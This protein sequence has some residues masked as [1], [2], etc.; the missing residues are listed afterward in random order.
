MKSAFIWIIAFCFFA[1]TTI[2]A[3]T[4]C[5][6]AD[7]IQYPVDTTT[8]SLAQDYGVPSQRH[9]GRY[10]TG[11]DW[12][13]GRGSSLG[14]PVR[15]AARGMVMLSSPNAW[16]RDGGV[17]ILR[18]DFAD[19]TTAFTQYG[20]ITQ[21]ETV[22]FPQPLTC[23]DAGEVIAVIGDA[24]PAPHLH[25]E[26]RVTNGDTPGPGYSWESPDSSGWRD[27]SDFIINMQSRLNP[28][29]AWRITINNPEIGL[30]TPPLVL[31]D[32]SLLYFDQ[33]TI[34]R[35]TAD[36]RVMWRLTLQQTPVGITGFQGFP[37]ATYADGTM[38]IV[39]IEGTL[40]E[41]WQTHESLTGYPLLADDLILF[42]TDDQ[43]IIALDRERRNVVWRVENV[44][45]PVRWHQA[46]N[47]I[48]G[49]MTATEEVITLSPDG[50]MLDRATLRELGSLATSFDGSLL[51]YSKGGL[52]QVDETGT[53]SVF[54]EN[55][56]AGGYQSGITVTTE[57]TLVLF[58]G[59]TLY[60]YSQDHALMWE[61]PINEVEGKVEL[62]DYGDALLLLSGTG[63]IVVINKSGG[64]CNRLQV[65]GDDRASLWHDLGS[66]GILRVAVGDQ[67]LGLDWA[68]LTRVC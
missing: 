8:F 63:D 19:G 51:I 12:H 18:H 28:A 20:H 13:G 68:Q 21:S 29:S 52:W 33:N 24:R 2:Y 38:Q 60:G 4:D 36:G 41:T 43:A 55:A 58:D 42:P 53:W 62:A 67:L 47:G 35:A 44:P 66:D 46:N 14:Q 11:E 64:A 50:Q 32:N 40:G 31:D 6:A 37:L 15:A 45:A 22:Q 9:Q 54:M 59:E 25:F 39:S 57:N 26:V 56:P 34:R 17:I 16:G 27:P 10:H 48:I 30:I 65:A 3:Q 23:V 7:S 1:I 49:I 61:E 5:G